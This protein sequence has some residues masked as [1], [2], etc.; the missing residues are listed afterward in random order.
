MLL[1]LLLLT[2][3]V[4]DDGSEGGEPAL[5]LVSGLGCEQVAF[6][7]EIPLDFAVGP[8]RSA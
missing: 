7:C 3:L 5:S 6:L 4:V 8:G 1:L 2:R